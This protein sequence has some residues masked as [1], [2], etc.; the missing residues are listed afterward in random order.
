ME[1]P[2]VAGGQGR[3]A[4]H[5]D[6]QVAE[7][8]L[9]LGVAG[10]VDPLH[11]EGGGELGAVGLPL[12]EERLELL[13]H[14]GDGHLHGVLGGVALGDGGL[15]GDLLGRGGRGHEHHAGKRE[16]RDDEKER[17]LLH[18]SLPFVEIYTMES[19][20]SWPVASPYRRMPSRYSSRR[21]ST[22]DTWR[23]V[24][25]LPFR[26]TSRLSLRRRATS[27]ALFPLLA[28]SRMLNTSSTSWGATTKPL[29]CRRKP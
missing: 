28:S 3:H 11:H 9:Q 14:L 10:V 25:G 26:R 7:L 21:L 1:L 29:F 12:P 27:E 23:G 24:Q 6:V 2:F 15:V 19:P 4:R 22:A 8:V 13:R 20:L 18:R 16:N 17:V 5:G